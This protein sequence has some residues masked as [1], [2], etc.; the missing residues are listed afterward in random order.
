MK[1][2]LVFLTMAVL[3]L[4]L[5]GCLAIS[6][7]AN[8]PPIASFSYTVD[9]QQVSFDGSGSGDSD[10][11]VIRWQWNYGDGESGAEETAQ[12]TYNSYGPYEVTLRVV[13][14]GA[15]CSEASRTITLTAPAPTPEPVGLPV[16]S[17]T[18]VQSGSCVAFDGSASYDVHVGGYGTPTA[19][20]Y[21]DRAS[22]SFGD[23]TGV[24]AYWTWL[25]VPMAMYAD[26][27]YGTPGHYR[28]TLT[29]RDNE[30]NSATVERYITI[31]EEE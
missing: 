18:Y 15:S 17:F 31:V 12:H 28:V 9:G 30:G 6:P 24:S 4:G 22:W 26:H 13:D 3:T 20:G 2:V 7:G 14:N 21:I 29:V 23:G 27:E 25:G 1:K 19:D 5:F 11:Q 10:G 8:I 16:A